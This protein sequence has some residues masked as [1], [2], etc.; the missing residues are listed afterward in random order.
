MGGELFISYSHKDQPFVRQLGVY[1]EQEEIPPWVD[2]QLDYGDSWQGVIVE[3]IRRCAAFLV[4]MSSPARE[5]AFVT[6]ELAIAIEDGKTIL[7]VLIGGEA[8]DEVRHLQLLDM[9]NPAWPNYRFVERL[10]NIATPGRVPSIEVQRR[11]VEM[12]VG[13]MLRFMMG[14]TTPIVTFGVGFEADY[15]VDLTKSMQELG[16][17]EM[18]WAELLQVLNEQLPGKNFDLSFKDYGTLRFPRITSLIDHLLTKIDWN[19]LRRFDVVWR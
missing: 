19:D 4:V 8:F 15:G 2:N 9:R 1:L 7:P 11:R 14:S 6:K 18:E 10:R 12:C 5:S 16:F 17:D 3:R 13:M